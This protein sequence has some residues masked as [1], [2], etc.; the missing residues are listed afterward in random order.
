MASNQSWNHLGKHLRLMRGLR[1]LGHLRVEA[2]QI[3]LHSNADGVKALWERAWALDTAHGVLHWLRRR[4]ALSL[5]HLLAKMHL[6]RVG[7]MSLLLWRG[8]ALG[9]LLLMLKRH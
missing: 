2:L 3:R 4:L 5:W 6:K 9:Q 8:K 7:A 1:N